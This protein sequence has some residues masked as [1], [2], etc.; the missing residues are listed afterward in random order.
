MKTTG[1]TGLVVAFSLVV[2]LS[3]PAATFAAGMCSPPC[4]PGSACECHTVIACDESDAEGKCI[5]H[6]QYQD[7]V[8]KEV[9]Q[10]PV[11]KGNKKK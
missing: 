1:T 9:V 10:Q 2:W 3:A 6:R 8:C 4:P 7:C 5:K 11:Y